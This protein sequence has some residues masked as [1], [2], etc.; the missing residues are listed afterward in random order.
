ML[1]DVANL[2]RMP[3]HAQREISASVVALQ[4]HDFEATLQRDDHW[5]ATKEAGVVGGSSSTEA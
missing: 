4:V 5:D 3:D 2:I 1:G